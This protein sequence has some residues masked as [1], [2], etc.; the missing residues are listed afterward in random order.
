MAADIWTLTLSSDSPLYLTG[1]AVVAIDGRIGT[2]DDRSLHADS[3]YFVV[4]TGWWIFQ[5]K[6]LLPAGL[7]RSISRAEQA[8][9]LAMTKRDV[10]S[11][12]VYK[13][14]EHS[15]ASGRYNDFYGNS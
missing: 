7:I 10:R 8:I 5:R 9:Y 14:V 1:Y 6:R 15:S 12:P 2:I 13:P 11:A 3:C 4:N